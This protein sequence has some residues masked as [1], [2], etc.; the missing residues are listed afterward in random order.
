MESR[1]AF[2]LLAL[3]ACTQQPSRTTPAAVPSGWI[4]VQPPLPGTEGARCANWAQDEWEVALSRDSNALLIQPAA[5]RYTDTLQVSGG[6][7]TSVN[8]GEFGGK[9]FW[10]PSDGPRQQIAEMNLVAFVPT[11]TGIFALA[12][13]AHLS[14]NEGRL[15]RFVHSTAGSWSVM[16]VADLGA[17]PRAFALLPHDTILV[18]VSGGLIAI[19]PEGE[20]RVLHRNAVWSSTYAHAVVR[21]RSGIIYVGM[22]S[23]VAR[24]TP[25]TGA[26]REGWLVPQGCS[27]RYKVSDFE[28]CRCPGSA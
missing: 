8:R 24:L 6:I 21:D 25:D 17:A 28:E 12:G 19:H 15:L 1:L 14:T 18:V 23:A 9:V 26:L 2:T 10:E 11:S 22:R 27:Q 13:L 5:H 16:P 3:T 20:P 7:L 4:L